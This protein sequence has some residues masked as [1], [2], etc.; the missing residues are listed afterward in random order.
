LENPALLNQQL[1]HHYEASQ[2]SLLHRALGASPSNPLRKA[3]EVSQFNLLCELQ[4]DS[5]SS[6][7]RKATQV[8]RFSSQIHISLRMGI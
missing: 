4:E 5:Q 2:S 8:N 1:S 6:H 7:P 3:L